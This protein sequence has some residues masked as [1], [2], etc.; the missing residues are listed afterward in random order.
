MAHSHKILRDVV[1]VRQLALQGPLRSRIDTKE[2]TRNSGHVPLPER[3]SVLT[4]SSLLSGPWRAG[5][6]QYRMGRIPLAGAVI[7]TQPPPANSYN[8]NPVLQ[9]DVE[10]LVSKLF[11]GGVLQQGTLDCFIVI[12]PPG[13]SGPPN[14]TGDHWM[15]LDINA[16]TGAGTTW[17]GYVLN[18]SESVMTST[19]CH[20]LAEMCTDPQGTGWQVNPRNS[21]PGGSWNEIGDVCQALTSN[22][23]GVTVQGYRSVKGLNSLVDQ[24][25]GSTL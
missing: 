12:L 3:A 22:L 6:R 2:V 16:P 15:F 8:N 20:E 1:S 23:A 4:A 24:L 11:D 17:V 19:F 18:G 5:L 14:I 13:T 10:A 25:F 7:V 9:G 21:G